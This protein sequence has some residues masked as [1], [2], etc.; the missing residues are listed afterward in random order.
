MALTPDNAYL[1][2]ATGSTNCV[3]NIS[4]RQLA[5]TVTDAGGAGAFGVAFS[6]DGTMM[7]TGDD[8]GSVYLWNITSD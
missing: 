5:A 6:G 1:A 4:T 7:A 8:N 3:W 2:V